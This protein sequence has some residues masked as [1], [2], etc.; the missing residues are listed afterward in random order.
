MTVRLGTGT[1]TDTGAG[2]GAFTE[3]YVAVQQFYA[4]HMH[5][6]DAGAAQEW[7]DTFTEDAVIELPS[8]APV[9]GRATLAENMGRGFRE[10]AER[11]EVQRHWHGMLALDARP[12]GTLAVRCYALVILSTAEGSRLHRACV[13]EDVLVREE[14]RLR[15][16][17][18]RVTR[19]DL[20]G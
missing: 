16:R 6:L 12:D 13:C 2:T 17:S 7:A 4:R 20:I 14:G 19:D 8:A 5:L 9:A 15:V 18:R 11:G 3:A 10:S 1:G